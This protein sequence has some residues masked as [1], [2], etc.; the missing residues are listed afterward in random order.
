MKLITT[1]KNL[2]KHEAIFSSMEAAYEAANRMS[3][4]SGQI[5]RVEIDTGDG[6]RAL[7]D[8]NW[9]KESKAKGLRM[10]E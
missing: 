8:K 5:K 4:S 6:L 9:T 1:F 10:P 2:Y 7:W 3:L